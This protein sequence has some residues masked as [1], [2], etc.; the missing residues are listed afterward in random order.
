MAFPGWILLFDPEGESFET[1]QFDGNV[2]VMTLP[3]PPGCLLESL[4]PSE[5]TPAAMGILIRHLLSM[6]ASKENDETEMDGN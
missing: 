4:S 2:T 3:A 6:L 5:P 1:S